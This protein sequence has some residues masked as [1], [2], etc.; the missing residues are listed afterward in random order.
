V[1]LG[2]EFTQVGPAEID[3]EAGKATVKVLME[4]GIDL[5]DVEV[6]VRS[7]YRSKV[8]P[9]SG[10]HID[11]ENNNNQVTYTITS[12]SGNKREWTVELVPFTEEIL[13]SYDV[14]GL[15]V[16]GGTGPEY[17]GAEVIN[18]T[19]KPWLWT[20][21]DGP[22]AEL[23]N[24]LTFEFTGVTDDGK[25]YGTFTNAAGAD[26]KYADFVYMPD[27]STDVNH[28]YRTMPK[29]TGTWQH[30][31]TNNTI[32]FIFG[33]GTSYSALFKGSQTVTLGKNQDNQDYTKVITDHAFEFT[34]NGTDDWGSIYSDYDKVVK[35]PRRFWVDV[36]RN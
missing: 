29:G 8:S 5:S 32:K 12:E 14:E 6:I 20:E 26:G 23:D 18:M 16:F 22:S 25:T 30:D 9:A 15:V 19:A 3:R 33:N 7:S 1:K 31:Y 13:G 11:F 4:P 17:N 2:G 24:T 34:L 21:S 28:F 10:E 36:K 27:P 35:K